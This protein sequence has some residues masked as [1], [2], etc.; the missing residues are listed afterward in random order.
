[1]TRARR[2]D[3]V[4]GESLMPHAV[5]NA[6]LCLTDPA[7]PNAIINNKAAGMHP[8]PMRSRQA[9]STVSGWRSILSFK[10]A[11]M[12][13]PTREATGQPSMKE[14]NIKQRLKHTE[15]TQTLKGKDGSHST[16]TD[17]GRGPLG[18]DDD[19]QRMVTSYSDPHLN[20]S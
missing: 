7:W 12:I 13:I 9:R 14:N 17:S 16:T 8:S 10:P 18:R 6:P 19:I 5:A 1:M 11:T 2:H 3:C 15:L 4:D 20:C